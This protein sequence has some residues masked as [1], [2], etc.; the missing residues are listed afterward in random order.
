MTFMLSLQKL[1]WTYKLFSIPT[2]RCDWWYF[3]LEKTAQ[4]KIFCLSLFINFVAAI[5]FSILLKIVCIS[6]IA[7]YFTSNSIEII[8]WFAFISIKNKIWI[9]RAMIF[10]DTI[11]NWNFWIFYLFSVQLFRRYQI[12]GKYFHK[13]RWRIGIWQSFRNNFK[14]LI[15]WHFQ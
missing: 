8:I 12:N 2:Y 15:K 4:N 1:S 13:T 3:F 10:A 6:A 9:V 5:E 7:C 14:I 11:I